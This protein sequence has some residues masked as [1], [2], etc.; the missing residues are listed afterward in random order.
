VKV[1]FMAITIV[2]A[3][4]LSLV[5]ALAGPVAAIAPV[6]WNVSG[7]WV[8]DFLEGSTVVSTYGV[9]LSQIGTALTGTAVFPI[10]GPTVYGW[11]IT[12]AV[13]NGIDFTATYTTTPTNG[14]PGPVTVNGTIASDG[15]MS[16]TWSQAS[17]AG[18]GSWAT[19]SGHATAGSTATFYGTDTHATID[20]T[21]PTVPN[22][23]PFVFGD[24]VTISSADGAVVVVLN[25]QSPSLWTVTAKDLNTDAWSGYMT[26]AGE[27]GKLINQ[28]LISP[29]NFVAQYWANTGFS[30]SGS[31]FPVPAGPLP[32]YAKQNITNADAAGTYSITIVFA[33]SLS[34]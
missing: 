7:N 33:A 6:S 17:P 34:F 22:F 32:F 4:V 13:T 18:S 31:V 26:T 9:T 14:Y 23:A 25:S 28:L 30:Y 5:L 15:S 27:T 20:V 11:T 16:G 21:A 10:S 24:N 29:N 2:L 8:F 12:G 3:L 1:K 19:T